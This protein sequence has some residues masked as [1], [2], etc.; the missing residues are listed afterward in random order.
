M[1]KLTE[2]MWAYV[3]CLPIYGVCIV[4]NYTGWAI[5]NRP[6]YMSANYVFQK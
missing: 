6:P 3:S 5:K 1:R 2:N 4:S